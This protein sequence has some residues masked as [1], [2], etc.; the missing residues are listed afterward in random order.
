MLNGQRRAKSV[1][2]TTRSLELFQKAGFPSSP[3]RE[4]NVLADRHIDFIERTQTNL[5]SCNTLLMRKSMRITV[6]DTPGK[7][8][9]VFATSEIQSGELIESTEIIVVPSEQR[10]FLDT[11]V[12][13][14]YYFSWGAEA[15]EAA[16]ALGFG[17][18]YNHSYSPNAHYVKDLIRQKIDFVAIRNISAGEE[19]T[20]NYNGDPASLKPL[21]FD[22]AKEDDEGKK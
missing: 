5:P 4:E 15:N 9:G 18:L 8:R 20:V 14:N 21:W 22:T 10:S 19:I 13:Y 6:K 12:L 7:G 17:S 11:T 16:L 1:R 2:Y 3:K